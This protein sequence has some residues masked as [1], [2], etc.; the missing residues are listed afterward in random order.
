MLRGQRD[1]RVVQW[2]WPDGRPYNE[3]PYRL[4][5]IFR[6]ILSEIMR[7]AEHKRGHKRA[8]NN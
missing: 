7:S 3:Q 2:C 4:V 5:Q 1:G 8:S 6:V